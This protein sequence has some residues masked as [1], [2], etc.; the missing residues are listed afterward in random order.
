VNDDSD[1]IRVIEG[2][3]AASERCVVEA[4]FGRSDLPNESRELAPNFFAAEA[5]ALGGEIELIPPF[6]LGI[7]RQWYLAGLLAPD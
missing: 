1:V 2:C 7:W 5:S 4:P 6:E 3:G